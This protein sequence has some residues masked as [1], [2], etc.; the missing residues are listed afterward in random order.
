MPRLPATKKGKAYLI[1]FFYG[2]NTFAS[3]QKLREVAESYIKKTGSNFGLERIEAERADLKT[4]ISAVAAVPFLATSRLVIIE[5][6]SQNKTAASSVAKIIESIPT[7]TVAVF[8]EGA[9]DSRG[10][11][12]KTLQKQAKVAKFEMLAPHALKAWI[13]KEVNVLGCEIDE[14]AI[15][16]LIESCGDDQWRLHNELH[17]LASFKAKISRDEVEALV[18]PTLQQTIF[19]LVDSMSQ[20]NTGRAISI[21]E[22]LTDAQTEDI[23]ILNMVTWQLRNLLLA[24]LAPS[25]SP[26]EL[27]KNTGMSPYVASKSITK[28]RSLDEDK[29]KKAYLASLRV[30]YEIKSGLGEPG[31]LVEQLI[32]RVSKSLAQ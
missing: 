10:V 20:Q 24:K 14:P 5:Y 30:N 17:K 29:L 23:Y 26:D 9:V 22:K 28:A 7:T 18:E 31:P 12:F 1:L 8:Y 11:Y 25:F 6:L 3:R 16:S 13:K 32:M 15:A 19:D 21:Y 2:P 4:L 27:A